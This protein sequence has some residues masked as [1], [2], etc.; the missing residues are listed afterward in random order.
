MDGM[1]G[2][3]LDVDLSSGE[4]KRVTYDELIYRAYLGGNGL[5]AK[6]IH[7]TVPADADPLGPENAVVFTVGPLT[8]TPLWGT[9]RGHVCGIS[10]QTGFFADS[11]FGGR[12]AIAQKRTGFDA[13][14]IL[15]LIHI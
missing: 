7:D 2:V 12:F 8:D 5:G 13:V 6:I 4:A 1:N 11:N 10:P 9:S 15:S 14:V 3:Y